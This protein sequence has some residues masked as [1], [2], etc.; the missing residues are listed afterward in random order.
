MYFLQV[1]KQKNMH[2]GS[3]ISEH[4]EEEKDFILQKNES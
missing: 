2:S 3:I 1:K 4:S